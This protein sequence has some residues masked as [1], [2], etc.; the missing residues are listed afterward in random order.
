MTTHAVDRPTASGRHSASQAGATDPARDTRWLDVVRVVA[1]TAVVTIHTAGPLL[2]QA[3]GIE[4]SAA[5]WWLADAVDAACRWSVPVFVMV[6][7]ALML[8]P[9]RVRPLREFYRRRARRILAPLTVWTVFYLVWRTTVLGDELSWRDS[10]RLTAV[11]DPFLHLYFLFVMAG[12]AAVT[13]FLQVLVRGCSRRALWA[14]AGLALAGGA[15]DQLLVRVVGAGE[16]NAVTRFLPFVGYYV[17]GWLLRDVVPRGAARRRL[18]CLALLGIASAAVLAGVAASGGRFSPLSGYAFDYLSPPVAASA[19]AAFP[20]LHALV[21]RAPRLLDGRS[22][23]ALR[24][25][26]DL[27]FGVFL[28]HP[29]VLDPLARWLPTPTTAPATAAYLLA[30]VLTVVA[31]AGLLTLVG[32]RVPYLRAVL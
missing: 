7:G 25:G 31:A 10:L 22:G 1:I 2:K 13:P 32:R 28:L 3:R 16:P 4:T 30:V 27:S 9:A 14:L 6:S 19:L 12:L 15:L 23:A 8:D 11:G 21:L 24:R 29:L 20:L 5:A 18:A 17:A 26:A